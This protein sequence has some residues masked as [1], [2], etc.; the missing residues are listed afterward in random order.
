MECFL[1][2]LILVAV[3]AAVVAS[4]QNDQKELLENDRVRDPVADAYQQR[5]LAS[6][7]ADYQ[8]SLTKLQ[9]EPSSTNRVNALNL[10]RRY[11]SLCR[12]GGQIAV[13]DEV[14]LQND[15]NSY[16]AGIR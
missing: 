9:Q 2:F 14:A 7:Y 16:G 12:E 8:N 3:F 13:F 4:T 10:G 1:A 11:A 5:I 6:A 15:L